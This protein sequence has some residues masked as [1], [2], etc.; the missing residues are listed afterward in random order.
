MI[1][2]WIATALAVGVIGVCLYLEE[3][4]TGKRVVSDGVVAS[5]NVV[6]TTRPLRPHEMR[7]Q[8]LTVPFP[9]AA[10]DFQFADYGEWLAAEFYLSFRAPPDVCVAYAHKVLD[11]HNKQHPREP[12]A[13]L[14]PFSLVRETPYGRVTL[15]APESKYLGHE[16]M[17][18]HWFRP[19]LIR[20]GVE[21]GD[22][23]R[24]PKVWVDTERGV[25]YYEYRH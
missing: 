6:Y 21:G 17:P 7:V 23:F 22:N 16:R 10:R 4:E 15:Q 2:P 3:R 1:L 20:E 25:F 14:K 8:M 11:E 13:G 12:V 24:T 9:G 19:D 18:L 5:G